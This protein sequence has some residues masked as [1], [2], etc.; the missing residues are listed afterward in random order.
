MNVLAVLI[1][2]GPLIAMSSFPVAAAL[3]APPIVNEPLLRVADNDDFAARKDAY[4]QQMR[5]EMTEWR[6][7]M[8]AAGERAEAAGHEASAE[9]KEHLKAAWTA[10]ERGWQ[11]LETESAEG[12]DKTKTAYERSTV[13]LRAQW[14]QIHPEDKD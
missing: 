10:T 4:L 1:V 11:K 7:K 9:T 8:E 12:W 14:H 3:L 2:G 13:E 6:K 5:D